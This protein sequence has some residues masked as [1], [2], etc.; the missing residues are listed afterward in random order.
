[1]RTGEQHDAGAI[2]VAVGRVRRR[3][4]EACRR[5]GR[6]SE[7]VRLIAV[8]KTVP[9]EMVERAAAAGIGDFGENYVQELEAKRPAAPKAIWHFIGRVQRNK[10]RRILAASDWVQTL[11][12]GG[13]TDLLARLAADRP[14]PVPCLVEVDFTGVRVGVPV[15]EAPAFVAGLRSAPGLEV[16]G[17]MTVAPLGEP[18]RPYFRRLRELRDALARDHPSVQ[19]LSMGMT[20]DLEE[21]VEEGATMVRVGAAIF[22][23]RP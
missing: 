18:P 22:G 13:A 11:E 16:R 6:R 3:V 20:A 2:E 14:V 8:T 15:E 17:L 19:E 21:A 1:M 5:A 4:E 10:V 12:P 7:D 9:A 23:P